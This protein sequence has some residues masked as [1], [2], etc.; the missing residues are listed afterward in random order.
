MTIDFAIPTP[1][2]SSEPYFDIGEG[3]FPV[4]TQSADA[5]AWF[6]RGL[7]WTF[8]FNHDEALYSFK[9]AVAH[10]PSF[11]MGWWGLSYRTGGNYNAS[12]A[13]LEKSQAIGKTLPIAV[14]AI[15]RAKSL[16]SAASPLE[17]TL[18]DALAERYPE[19]LSRRDFQAWEE[20]YAKRMRQIYQ[21]H[22]ENPNIAA[23]FA[24]SLMFVTPWKLWDLRTGRPAGNSHALEVQQ[25]LE[26]AMKREDPIANR[27]HSGI[28]HL[29]IHLMEMSSQPELAI[30]S[31]DRLRNLLPDAGHLNHM[32]SHID[33]LVGDYRKAIM[34][35]E[36]GILADN[37]Y[38]DR[39]RT[40]VDVTKVLRMHN[41]MVAV[42][43]AMFNGQFNMA[44]RYAK[45]LISWT[46]REAVEPY[47]FIVEPWLSVNIHILV[48]FGKW[49][50]IKKLELPDDQ[51][52]YPY[53]TAITYYARG[54]AFAAT[55]EV[56]RAQAERE[57]LIGAIERVPL[58]WMILPTNTAKNVLKVPLAMLD[59]EIAYREGNYGEA[60]SHLERAIAEYDG[61]AFGEP[62]PWM[63]PVRHAYAALK[64]EQGHIEDAMRAY[65]EDLGYVDTLP[66]ACQHPNNVWALHGY[67]ECLVKVGRTQEANLLQPQLRIALAVAD[68]KIASSCFCRLVANDVDELS[69]KANGAR[70]TENGDTCCH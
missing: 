62:W 37:K 23:L 18:I 6:D 51:K 21:E 32:P 33:V 15:E 5:Q 50:D 12:W 52:F 59:G 8:A 34:A 49:D 61:L 56:Q 27:F 36:L 7:I 65:G 2:P 10:D 69:T 45:L 29:Y 54:I 3:H 39:A 53:T 25:V 11:A 19:D 63:Q 68:T 58:H 57:G 31:A 42:Y 41:A 43:A 20:A 66:R 1:V 55:G 17:N 26:T 28:H 67:L 40:N 14:E 64:L 38:I 60:F 47:A 70:A 44:S 4:S 30:P 16:S 46:S 24:E 9:Q 22:S 48:R 35:N 13:F